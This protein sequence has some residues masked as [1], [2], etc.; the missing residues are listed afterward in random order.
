MSDFYKV[1]VMAEDAFGFYVKTDKSAEEI[2][3]ILVSAGTK[4]SLIPENV[5]TKQLTEDIVFV[6]SQIIPEIAFKDRFYGE[7]WEG[8]EPAEVYSVIISDISDILHDIKSVLKDSIKDIRLSK[9]PEERGFT[10]YVTSGDIWDDSAIPNLSEEYLDRY[11]ND[12]FLKD[13]PDY[14]LENEEELLGIEKNEER[15]M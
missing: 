14:Y 11:C 9:L 10:I 1:N 12:F 4:S 6:E 13:C 15:E 2:K 8:S 7:N 3:D 5:V